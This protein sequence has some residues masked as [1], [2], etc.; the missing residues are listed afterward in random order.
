MYYSRKTF[1]VS[2]CFG[3][4][5]LEL[6]VVIAILAISFYGMS[7]IQSE[8]DCYRK[9]EYVTREFK[10]IFYA[11]RTHSLRTSGSS[12]LR[13]GTTN[14]PADLIIAQHPDTLCEDE[15]TVIQ[16]HSVS[17]SSG[18]PNLPKNSIIACYT[19]GEIVQRFKDKTV[20]GAPVCD[21][22]VFRINIPSGIKLPYIESKA[23]N[24]EWKKLF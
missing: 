17:N 14:S 19:K 22:L 23:G 12:S 18:A 10:P 11:L 1:A 7:T 8:T 6:L 5:V 20:V 3:F 4:T 2:S 16:V 24:S 21:T 9:A 15:S 13:T